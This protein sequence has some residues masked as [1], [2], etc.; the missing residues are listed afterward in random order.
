M[1]VKSSLLFSSKVSD[2]LPMVV[3][4]EGNYLTLED[5]ITQKRKVVFDAVGGAAVAALGHGD[6][7]IVEAMSAAAKTSSY[8]FPAA[9]TNYPA[10]ELAKFVIEKSPEGA[11]SSVLFTCSGSETNENGMKTVYQYFLEK[12]QPERTKFIS[13]HQSYHG[14]T[15]GA[16]ALGDSL[17]KEPFTPITLPL[18]QV[19]KISQVYPY[20][21]QKEDESEAEYCARLVQ[22]LED[23]II[24]AGANEVAA[25]MLETLSGSTYGTAPALPGYLAGVRKVCDKYGVL[26]W[27]D[28]VMC[29]TGRA[30]ATGGLH[31]WESFPDFKG[32]DLQS[33][34]KTLGSG[35]VTIAGLLIS[36]KVHQ[37]FV[38][39]TN[40]IPGGQT[41][42][43]H[44]FNCLVALAV[45]K[46]IDRL[47]LRQNAFEQGE[48]VG[49]FLTEFSKDT[50]IVGN[51]RGLGAF[52]SIELVKNK[53]TK[54]PFPAEL[55][56]GP[57]IS[58]KCLENG[59]T[60][61][62]GTC[63]IDG[64]V[65]DHVTVAP[66]F[67]ITEKEAEFI[68]AT[69]IKSVKDVEADLIAAGHL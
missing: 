20:R 38:D 31:C 15:L 34:G 43:Q 64:K 22:E 35:F 29:G 30:S 42:H 3:K 10:E 27:L 16:L 26:M 21:H 11:F 6:E 54:E 12:G 37:V 14:Y 39:G 58:A 60:S 24:A 62:G 66:T 13:R 45:Q 44:A 57:K 68:A 46:K 41:Y 47:N 8:S 17:R 33:I 5:A 50:K 4:G 67:I 32:P 9:F 19:P 18:S 61:M 48:R 2:H 65:G 1:T 51:V 28:E 36:P 7:E 59:M 25:V 40:Y 53:D 52:W 63:T 55:T 56:V 69:L 23:T 49:K